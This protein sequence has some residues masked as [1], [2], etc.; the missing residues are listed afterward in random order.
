MATDII[1]EG[2]II[3]KKHPDDSPGPRIIMMMPRNTM[4]MSRIMIMMIPRIMMM[5]SKIMIMM[6]RITMMMATDITILM[7]GDMI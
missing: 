6:P 5:I 7:E 3:C 2:E 1:V 4:M